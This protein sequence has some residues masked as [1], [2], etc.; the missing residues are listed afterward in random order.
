SLASIPS[1]MIGSGVRIDTLVGTQRCGVRGQRSALSL[2]FLPL[3]IPQT[4]SHNPSEMS[5]ILFD[6]PSLRFLRRFRFFENMM[7]TFASLLVRWLSAS[8]WGSRQLY[9][10]LKEAEF[11]AASQSA[12]KLFEWTLSESRATDCASID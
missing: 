4:T 1:A 2:P 9:F 8:A 10:R 7:R 12:C 11:P 6:L 3:A 5:G